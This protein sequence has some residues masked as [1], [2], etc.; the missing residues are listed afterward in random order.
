LFM[1]CH[2]SAH[3]FNPWRQKRK[4][5]GLWWKIKLRSMFESW[6]IYSVLDVTAIGEVISLSS[7]H[8]S[9]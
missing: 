3:H 4:T 5:L 8:Y 7:G 6:H 1:C 9:K 2:Y